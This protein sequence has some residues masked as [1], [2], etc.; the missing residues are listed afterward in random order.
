MCLSVFTDG[1]EIRQLSECKHAFH[2]DCIE[3]WLKLHPNC[4]ICRADVSDKQ[5]TTEAAA[6]V[7]V[8]GNVNRSSGG[9][10]RVSATNRDDD[11]RQG[12]PDASSLV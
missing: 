3:E 6:N 8:N 1:E 5:Q 7:S 2:V 12:L 10:R 4:P 11:W 9:N